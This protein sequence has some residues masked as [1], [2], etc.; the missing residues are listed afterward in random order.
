MRCK[1]LGHN[2]SYRSRHIY[3]KQGDDGAANHYVRYVRLICN[4]CG[5]T[6]EVVLCDERHPVAA[7][8]DSCLLKESA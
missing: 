7:L 4:K 8:S 3:I 5:D 1:L 2:F 6:K